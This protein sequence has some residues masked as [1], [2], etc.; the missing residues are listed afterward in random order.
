MISPRLYLFLLLFVLWFWANSIFAP[1]AE[2]LN[3][4]LW[5]YDLLF[6]TRFVL[7]FWS[8]FEL[9]FAW[10]IVRNEQALKRQGL[11]NILA[12]GLTALCVSAYLFLMYTGYGFQ[13]R[14]KL[15]S[16]MLAELRQPA[17][18]NQRARIGWFLI[19]NQRQPCQ[20]EPWLWLGEVYGG[21]S[22]NNLALVYSKNKAPKTPMQQGFRFWPLPDHWWLAYQNPKRY[23]QHLNEHKA[24]VEGTLVRTH[25]QGMQFINAPAVIE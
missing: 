1:W 4:R 8:V 22:G 3:P 20:D 6:Y 15:S 11:A 5:L 24:C 17:H 21:G 23:Y 7:L 19:D 16:A 2:S 13:F 14:V 25:K 10:R 12:I 18:S 9:L